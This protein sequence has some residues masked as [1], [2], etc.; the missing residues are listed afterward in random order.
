MVFRDVERV[1]VVKISFDLAVVFDRV[2]ERHEDVFD[3]F[4]Q[5]RDRMP[6][7]GT[8]TAARHRHVD[9]VACRFFG[10]NMAF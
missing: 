9:T 2:T 8:R 4:A 10:F 1:E 3:S 5:Q 6:V 7:A